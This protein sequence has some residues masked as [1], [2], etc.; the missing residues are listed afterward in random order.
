MNCERCAELEMQL[1]QVR[2]ELSSVKLIVQM[3][4][5]EHVQKDTITTHIHHAEVK[6]QRNESWGMIAKKSTK[7]RPEGNMKLKDN[8]LVITKEVILT[9][10]RFAA[11]ATN[12]NTTN[13]GYGMKPACENLPNL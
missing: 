9:A 7:T 12:S 11:L 3:L 6:R 13:N 8:E 10:N 2:D 1:Q 5:K 4:H